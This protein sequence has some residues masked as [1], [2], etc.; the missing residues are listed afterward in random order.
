[1]LAIFCFLAGNETDFGCKH[2]IPWNN[3]NVF[4]RM[5]GLFSEVYVFNVL[6]SA[7]EQYCSCISFENRPAYMIGLEKQH[8]MAF[9]HLAEYI[10][11]H[12]MWRI[13]RPASVADGICVAPH[14]DCAGAVPVQL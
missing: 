9:R 5:D 8:C 11:R 12:D 13:R 14:A 4:P 1:M 10:F 2:V 7:S 3:Q 6:S